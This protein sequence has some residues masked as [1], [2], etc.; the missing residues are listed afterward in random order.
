MSLGFGVA[1]SFRNQDVVWGFGVSV[2]WSL[3]GFGVRVVY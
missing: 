1:L 2:V 3:T